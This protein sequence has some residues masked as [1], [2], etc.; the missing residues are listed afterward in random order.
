MQFDINLNAFNQSFEI[1][2]NETIN[3]IND[4][5]LCILLSP[6]WGDAFIPSIHLD[7]T[8]EWI[9]N[10]KDEIFISS[11]LRANEIN[12][13]RIQAVLHIDGTLRQ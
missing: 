8:D 2:N 5:N 1:I 9:D 6:P 3:N 12:K 13:H 4:N 10:Y 7:K 11:L